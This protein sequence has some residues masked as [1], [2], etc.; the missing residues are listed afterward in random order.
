MLQNSKRGRYCF[1]L[2]MTSGHKSYVLA[3]DS[4]AEFKDWLSKLNSVLQYN[5]LQE[6]KRAASLERGKR[7]LYFCD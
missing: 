1:E 6:E 4:E 5:K 2:R 7:T 3:A